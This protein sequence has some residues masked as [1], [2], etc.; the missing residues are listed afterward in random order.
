MAEQPPCGF[1]WQDEPAVSPA[2][3]VGKDVTRSGKSGAGRCSGRTGHD[4]YGY[5][6][7]VHAYFHQYGLSSVADRYPETLWPEYAASERVALGDGEAVSVFACDAEC[8]VRHTFFV[9]PGPAEAAQVG[10]G[11]AVEDA[12]EVIPGGVAVGIPF[13]VGLY[14]LAEGIAAHD[15]YEFFHHYRGLVVDDLTVDKSGIAQIGQFLGYGYGAL[16]AVF[17]Q[18]RCVERAQAVET[19]VDFRIQRLGYPCREMVCE[20]FFGPDL[21]EPF[22]GDQVSEPHVGR[23]MGY[24]FCP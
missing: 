4:R 15:L 12:Y 7:G 19:V 9:D 22:H 13:Q 21:I 23:F 16:G 14:A 1:P 10:R 24:Q 6:G 5:F 17:A 8:E 2:V 11:E 3:G 20:Y 18:G